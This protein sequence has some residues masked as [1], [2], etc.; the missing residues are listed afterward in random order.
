VKI[1]SLEFMSASETGFLFL[2]L[3]NRLNVCKQLMNTLR[4]WW[5][6]CRVGPNSRICLKTL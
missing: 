1:C 5:Q 6:Y 4:V 2:G 3:M